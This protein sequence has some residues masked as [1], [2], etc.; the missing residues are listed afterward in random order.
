MLHCSLTARSDF[1]HLAMH[2]EHLYN[3]V[4]VVFMDYTLAWNITNLPV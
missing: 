2:Q 3:S 1:T 4:V